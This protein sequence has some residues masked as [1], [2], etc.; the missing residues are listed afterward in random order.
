MCCYGSNKH[1]T[2]EP[3]SKEIVM[4]LSV[5]YILDHFTKYSLFGADIITPRC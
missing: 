2:I 1:G 3:V 5:S 4:I